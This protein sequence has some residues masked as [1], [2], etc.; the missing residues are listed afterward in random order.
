MAALLREPLAPYGCEVVEVP[1]VFEAT[2]DDLVRLRTVLAE[3]AALVSQPVR[4]EYHVAGCGTRQL[5]ALLPD[6]G[7]L[8]T[9]PVTYDSSAFPYQVNG[10]GGDGFRVEAP[11][12]DYHDLRALVAAEQGR[13]V[14]D[15]L[16]WWPA[17]VT[18]A[19]VTNAETSRAELRRRESDLD[20]GASD[21]L[22]PAAM[23][24]LSHPQNA[25]LAAVA[26][27][28][29]AALGLPDEDGEVPAREF[30]GERRAPV[31]AAVVEALGWP[32]GARHDRWVVR[33]EALEPRTVLETQLGWYAEHPDVVADAQHRYRK[34]RGLLGL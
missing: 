4:D 27:R 28:V 14:D 5:A 24:T 13:D 31:E 22:G 12:T 23:F 19:V 34:R 3:G 8:I 10:H 16:A 15:A 21:L 20:V 18:A 9:F 6:D 30:L 32:E 26:R 33:G 29:L 17:P 7:R 25:V 1:P 11:L 2:E